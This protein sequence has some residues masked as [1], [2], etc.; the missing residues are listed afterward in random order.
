MSEEQA[1]N[2]GMTVKTLLST[3]VKKIFSLQIRNPKRGLRYSITLFL[4][5]SFIWGI[6]L[7]TLF[8]K[9]PS[10][11][12]KWTLILPGTGASSTYNIQ[13]IGQI[14]TS[15]A[16]PFSNPSFSPK[17]VYKNII[18]SNEVARLAAKKA[19]TSTD[20]IKGFKVKLTDQTALID[21]TVKGNSPK[22][23]QDK[24]WAVYHAFSEIINNL[25]TNEAITRGKSYQNNLEEY[26]Q[27]L[28]K[29]RQKLSQYQAD[30]DIVSEK[31]FEQ[32][33]SFVETLS[34][35]VIVTKSNLKQS[36]GQK[37][38]LVKSL[39]ISSEIV[40]K[41]LT[42]QSD[43]VFQSALDSYSK[44]KQNLHDN[45]SRWG[46][47][48]PEMKKNIAISKS[49]Y[50]VLNTRSRKLLNEDTSNIISILGGVKADSKKSELFSELL[51]VDSQLLG[52]QSKSDELTQQEVL[53]KKKLNLHSKFAQELEELRKDYQIS[54]AIFTSYLTRTYSSKQDFF[55]SYP[56]FQMMSAPTLPLKK[57][58]PKAIILIP[59]ATFASIFFL[60]GLW[61][62]WIRKPFILKIFPNA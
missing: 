46:V 17:V 16:N 9:A 41:I 6:S 53:L 24:S 44:A 28:Q 51:L 34:Y 18:T 7:S 49:S 13:D 27:D 8:F 3:I 61:L 45:A 22:N 35:Q 55:G 39:G 19:N 42:L 26:K 5:L 10:F 54:E 50:K 31:Q 25:R 32:L 23:A 11:E 57:S 60:I 56:L 59:A 52:L 1:S 2:Q 4:V 12:S 43:K 29:K 38:S 37:F 21:F 62:M 14:S 33:A 30:S 15:G 36:Q 58:S 20:N 47:K 48:H 40:S